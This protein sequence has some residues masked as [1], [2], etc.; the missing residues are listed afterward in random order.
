MSNDR[1]RPRSGSET[2]VVSE[3]ATGSELN[4]LSADP[5]GLWGQLTAVQNDTIGTRLLLTCFF[6]LLLG[7]SFDSL[8]MRVHLAVP[9]NTLLSP[10][11]TMRC[12][13]ITARS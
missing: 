12:S 2:P 4:R 1:G 3:P 9:G 8:A 11:C 5:S 10:S 6:F 13:P 7:G